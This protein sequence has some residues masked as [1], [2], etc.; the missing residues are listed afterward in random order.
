M[1]RGGT[2]KRGKKWHTPATQIIKNFNKRCR[3]KTKES[4]E[5]SSK[6]AFLM[7]KV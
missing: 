2:K 1:G 5:K 4:G 7:E 6:V 3:E